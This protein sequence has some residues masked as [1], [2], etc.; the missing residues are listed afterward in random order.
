MPAPERRIAAIDIGTNSIHMIVAELRGDGGYRVVD[1]EKEMVQLGLSSLGGAPLSEE[2]MERGVAAIAHMAEVAR[3]WETEEIVAVA[4]S[5][6]REAPNR[7]EFLRRVKEAADVR[8]KVISGE[9]EADYIYRAVRAAV[10]LDAGS[11]LLCVDIGGGSVELVVG[12]VREIYYTASEPLGSLRLAQRFRLEE[13]PRPQDVEACR[14]H[15]ADHLRRVAKRINPLGFDVCVGTSGTIQALTNLAASAGDTAPPALRPLAHEALK[16]VLASLCRS[17]LPQRI[18]RMGLDPKRA[19]NIVAGA[20]VLDQAMRLMRI[21]SL[22]ACPAAIREGI[23]ESRI[24]GTP[25]RAGNSLRRKSAL[26]LINRSDCDKRHARHVAKLALRIFDQT[27]MLHALPDESRELLEHAALLHETG[28]QVSDRGYHK[29]T[30]YL[31]R[32]AHLRGFTEEQVILVA[33]VARYHRKSPPADD[34]PNLEELTAAQR[35]DVEKLAAIL[36]IAE[37]LDRSHKQTVR[38]VAVR[39][40]GNVKIAVRTRSDAAVEIAAATKRAKY[41]AALFERKVRIET[42]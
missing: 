15:T 10:E 20:I 37:A 40:N 9:E 32:H 24:A 26:A 7:R 29:H 21:A 25:Q 8:V 34:H 27:R 39:F 18:E 30:Y 3:G 11:T 2:A 28:M 41:F 23:I 19:R 5:A 35:G 42:S 17:T 38:D 1:K 31:I 4:T 33:N 12:T 14:R 13:T 16:Q 22:L 36:R 6:V